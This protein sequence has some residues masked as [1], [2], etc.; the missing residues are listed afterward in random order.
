M[1][2]GMGSTKT[3]LLIIT[4]LLAPGGLFLLAWLLCRGLLRRIRG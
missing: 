2:G 3:A 1:L 4:G